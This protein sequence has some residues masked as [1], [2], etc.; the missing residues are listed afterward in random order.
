[1]FSVSIAAAM[2]D[3]FQTRLSIPNSDGDLESISSSVL[4]CMSVKIVGRPDRSMGCM[5]S[6]P[7]VLKAC[8]VFRTVR[9]E[10]PNSLAMSFVVSPSSED[11]SNLARLLILASG[12]LAYPWSVDSSLVSGFR[13]LIGM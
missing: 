11:M 8:M 10:T 6:R 13:M 7:S 2:S 4:L 5:E 1:M 9:S 3:S 12:E